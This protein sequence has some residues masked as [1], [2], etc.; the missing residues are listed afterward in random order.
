MNNYKEKYLKYY[1][2]YLKLKNNTLKGGSTRQEISIETNNDSDNIN[3]F[4][5]PEFNKKKIYIIQKKTITINDKIFYLIEI[6]LNNDTE[7][8]ILFALAGLSHKSFIGTS[9]IILSKLDD[10]AKKFQ[11]VYL[12]EYASF[13]KEQ[14]N[15]CKERDELILEYAKK[16]I[17]EQKF[18][19]ETK[20]KD[21][22][23]I[24]EYAYNIY[25]KELSL[26]DK[27]EGEYYEP[28]LQMNERIAD[29][30]DKIITKLKLSNI[31]LLGKCNGAWIVT[32]LLA[33]SVEYKSLYLAVPGIPYSV[34]SLESI[35]VS[36]LKEINFIFGWIK[37]D[38]YEFNWNQTSYEEISRYKK[39]TKDLNIKVI[40][41]EYDN[42]CKADKKNYHEIYPKMIDIIL[43]SL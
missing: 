20:E 33:K 6:K 28:E 29:Y 26:D 19:N 35:P 24:Y 43:E 40:Y 34:K 36:R 25:K 18:E 31:H 10:L 38:R 11:T 8:P 21:K 42:G 14:S 17:T 23:E 30:V 5:A 37:Q 39:I 4:F 12:L 1:N 22:E 9:N 2:K 13:S 27:L 15:A 3:A 32:L 7:K 41:D 16:E